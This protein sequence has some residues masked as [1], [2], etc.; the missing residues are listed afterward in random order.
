MHLPFIRANCREPRPRCV[1]FAFDY[2]FN[3]AAYASGRFMAANNF[4][5]KPACYISSLSWRE[6]RLLLASRLT[7][8]G[9]A[10]WYF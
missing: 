8:S 6:R 1:A 5:A 3:G 2:R 4:A 9:K 7:P 10:P